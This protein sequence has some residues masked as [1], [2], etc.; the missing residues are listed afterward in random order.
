MQVIVIDLFCKLDY[1]K[2][3]IKISNRR[4]WPLWPQFVGASW[5]VKHTKVHHSNTDMPRRFAASPQVVAAGLRFMADF[6]SL[7]ATV[8]STLYSVLEKL[9]NLLRSAYMKKS[10]SAVITHLKYTRSGYKSR[11][12]DPYSE[13][14]TNIPCLQ[15]RTDHTWHYNNRHSIINRQQSDNENNVR[16][17]K[18]DLFIGMRLDNRAE[19]GSKLCVPGIGRLIYDKFDINAST[20]V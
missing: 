14:D 18:V 6:R 12:D 8:F 1:G 9:C 10:L 4:L 19:I 16:L 20:S 15:V 17:Q 5:N 3:C 2:E 13:S 7:N 11:N